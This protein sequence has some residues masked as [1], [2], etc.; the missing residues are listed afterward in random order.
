[1]TEATA[2]GDLL[3]AVALD[4]SIRPWRVS[5]GPALLAAWSDPD[6]ARWNGVPPAPSIDAAERW[7]RGAARQTTASASVDVVAVDAEDRVQGEVGLVL[8]RQ[9]RIAEVGF[10]VGPDHRRSGVG[11]RLLDAAG[12]LIPALDIER[13]FAITSAEN[14]AALALLEAN[15][16]P[17]VA[18]TTADRRAFVAPSRPAQP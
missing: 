5:D 14:T 10:W 12:R 11:S 17:E 1:M 15:G 7:L 6:V 2:I 16:W 3:S 9:R 4:P 13:A 18:T 8:D